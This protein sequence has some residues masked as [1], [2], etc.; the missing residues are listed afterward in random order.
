MEFRILGPLEV[1]DS[2]GSLL[3]IPAAMQRSLLALLLIHN[4]EVQSKDRIMDALWGEDPPAG[5]H[6][7][8]R[9]HVSKLRSCLGSESDRLVTQ[10]PG[11]LLQA[12]ND[13]IDANLFEMAITEA[14]SILEDDPMSAGKRYRDALEL[15]RGPALV[16]VEYETF[17][18]TEIARLEE[19]KLAALEGR[20]E[21]DLGAGRH[22]ELVG[23]L[24]ALVSEYPLRER[25]WAALMTA[26]YR[27]GRQSD[28]LRAYQEARNVLGDEL[29]IEPSEELRDLEDKVLLHDESI[30]TPVPPTRGGSLPIPVSTFV[31]R[32]R[33]LSTIR[34]LLRK[35]RLLTL[36]GVG[37]VGKTR[38]ALEIAS[39]A[40]DEY[41]DGV[42]YVDL[43][44][45]D[46]AEMVPLG[47]ADVLGLRTRSE[48]LVSHDILA[49]LARTESLL[50]FDNCEHL[51]EGV[52][53]LAAEILA[54][55]PQVKVL[56]TSRELLDV[57]GEVTL[58]VPPMVVPTEG[59]EEVVDADCVA[60]FVERAQAATPHVEFAETDIETIRG[61]CGVL[62]GLPLAIEL[63]AARTR[64]LSLQQ[65]EKRLDDRFSV[66]SARSRAGPARQRT[67]QAAIDWSYELLATA[68][69]RLFSSLCLFAGTFSLDAAEAV[70]AAV[71]PQED[72]L[73]LVGSLVDKSLLTRSDDR[74]HM[75]PTLRRF[76]AAKAE[77]HDLVPAKR[78]V[79]ELLIGIAEQA[80]SR[81][82]MPDGASWGERLRVEHSNL[83]S[84]L[85]WSIDAG[86]T[87]GA[88]RM[89]GALALHWTRSGLWSESP[90]WLR[91][92]A[93]S[94]SDAPATVRLREG[95][96]VLRGIDDPAAAL[97]ALA[98]LASGDG[99]HTRAVRLYGA[100]GA[101]R[102]GLQGATSRAAD[103]SRQ[104]R[105]LGDELFEQA[106][107][108]GRLLVGMAPEGAQ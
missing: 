87:D 46:S 2:S 85:A 43:A 52:A 29:G 102:E 86:D 71:A 6:N 48:A 8:L 4:N 103:Y 25:L 37:G 61:L 28:A 64:V 69:Q 30:D 44:S 99:E 50:L 31:G 1:V 65:L 13:E 88:L 20:F 12:A 3:N 92:A 39:G 59:S 74:F 35:G 26:L 106:W 9:F 100:A 32:K 63:A 41:A 5:G 7:T 15:W 10:P 11:Y 34:R 75:L 60:L 104:R 33:E 73:D 70:V 83:R 82:A 95:L 96:M 16:D 38:L 47:L 53:E 107:R 55:C 77:P 58:A 78:K 27:S 62:D 105:L 68:E 98:D 51:V 54:S 42:W 23:E 93:S 40:Q 72:A 81:M 76:A 79:V 22:D 21:A 101:I 45:L 108:E 24:R 17:A 66:L 19:M 89:A 36:T 94:G 49:R 67:L 80:E 90:L 14:G 84:A 18:R 97:E 57:A 91:R 56:A